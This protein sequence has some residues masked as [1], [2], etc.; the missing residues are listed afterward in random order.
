[1]PNAWGP[2]RDAHS[3]DGKRFVVRADENW[4]CFWNSDLGYSSDR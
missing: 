3:D 4:R 2:N 1:M